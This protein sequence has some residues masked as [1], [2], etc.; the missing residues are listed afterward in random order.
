[1]RNIDTFDL[2]ISVASTL[3][4]CSLL[5]VLFF[6]QNFLEIVVLKVRRFLKRASRPV[7]GQKI[8]GYAYTN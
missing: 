5:S 4:G 2:C 7:Y 3:L 6:D 8:G 1:M